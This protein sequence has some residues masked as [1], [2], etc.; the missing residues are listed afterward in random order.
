MN[1]DPIEFNDVCQNLPANDP[2]EKAADQIWADLY[3]SK[4]E[5]AAIIRE[6]VE[7]S[8]RKWA[9]NAKVAYMQGQADQR[10]QAMAEL[11]KQAQDLDMGY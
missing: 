8:K 2:I 4:D 9:D 5:V 10:E 7:A 3:I 6:A 11:T 1:E